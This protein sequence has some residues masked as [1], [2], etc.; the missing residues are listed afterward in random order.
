MDMNK[1]LYTKIVPFLCIGMPVRFGTKGLWRIV[2]FNEDGSVVIEHHALGK[3]T[4]PEIAVHPI[5]GHVWFEAVQG[6]PSIIRYG[7][8]ELWKE[9]KDE[10]AFADECL[11][12][13]AAPGED[14]STTSE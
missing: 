14:M 7:F 13:E 8:D 12:Q 11:S 9:L 5:D 3:F 1:P 10:I 2:H 6:G 4:I